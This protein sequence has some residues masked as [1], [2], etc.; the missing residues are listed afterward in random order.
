[1]L[2]PSYSL[3]KSAL[4][5]VGLYLQPA[6]KSADGWRKLAER[7][8]LRMG[9]VMGARCLFLIASLGAAVFDAGLLACAAVGA[10]AVSM[11]LPDDW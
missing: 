4:W 3:E 2:I 6:K 11:L 10:V 1:M 9:G 8:A 7:A 5:T